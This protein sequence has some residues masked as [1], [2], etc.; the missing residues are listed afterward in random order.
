M[1]LFCLFKAQFQSPIGTNKTLNLFKNCLVKLKS[2]NPLQVQTKRIVWS[3]KKMQEKLFQSPIGTNKTAHVMIHQFR[4]LVF[5][6][7]I[8]TNKTVLIF[9]L[10][11]M[12]QLFQS[13]IGT[14]KTCKKNTHLGGAYSVSIP[15]RY[16]QNKFY[17]W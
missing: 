5:Q 6:S 3:P 15:Y 9:L 17:T 2:F 14:N 12:H 7:P 13:P 8:G 4:D 16:K 10:Q 1:Y 11:E